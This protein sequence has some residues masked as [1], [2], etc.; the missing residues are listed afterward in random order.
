[1]QQANITLK[2]SRIVDYQARVNPKEHTI[3][4]KPDV[5]VQMKKPL[6]ETDRSR[7]LVFQVVISSE[8]K[9]EF[10]ITMT[11]ELIFSFGEDISEDLDEVAKRECFPIAIKDISERIDKILS[12]M[13]YPPIGFENV[14]IAPED[15]D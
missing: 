4:L 14:L 7:L 2:Q 8:I 1:M 11:E 5:S 12:T 10:Y 9:D 6:D 13:G 15:R 3:T